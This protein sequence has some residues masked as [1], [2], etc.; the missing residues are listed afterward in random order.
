M[1]RT[2]QLNT[3]VWRIDI[4]RDVP[5]RSTFDASLETLPLWSPD[6]LRLPLLPSATAPSIY[7]KKQRPAR[8]ANG[9]CL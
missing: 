3:D 6:G 4:G 8:E 7:L 1:Y 2:V 9:R 5:S